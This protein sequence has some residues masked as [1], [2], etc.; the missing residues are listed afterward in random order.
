LC[1]HKL[2]RSGLQD[3]NRTGDHERTWGRLS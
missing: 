2:P 3:N 1:Q